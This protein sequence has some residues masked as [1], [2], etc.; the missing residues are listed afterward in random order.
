MAV[1][2]VTAHT[3]GAVINIVELDYKGLVAEYHLIRTEVWRRAIFH[4]LS[5]NFTLHKLMTVWE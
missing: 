2:C 3:K 4:E 1:A 5:Y